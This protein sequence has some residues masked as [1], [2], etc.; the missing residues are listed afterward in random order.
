MIFPGL[1]GTPHPDRPDA[2]PAVEYARMSDLDNDARIPDQFSR[3]EAYGDRTGAYWIA[4]CFWDDGISAWR[5]DAHRPQFEEFLEVLRSEKYRTVV[6]WE[7]SRITRDPVVGAKFGR[8]MQRLRGVL[9]VTDGEKA[10]VYNFARQ[11]DRDS[12]H[13]AVGKSVS[14]SGLKSELVKRKQETK[15]EA[16]EF[17]GSPVGFGW[18]STIV[19]RGRKFHTVWSVDESQ[20]VW[21]REAARRIR[22]G[23]GAL[24]V[25]NDFYD[26][27]LRIPHRRTGPNDTATEG[28][29]TAQTLT[30]TLRNP[31][32]AGL[33]GSGDANTGWTVVGPIVNFPGILSED[34][35]RETVAALGTAPKRRGTS[36]RV[37]HTYAGW[38]VCHKCGRSLIRNSP[39][40]DALWRHRLGKARTHFECDQS[41]HIAAAAAE[42]MMDEL[43]S[44]YLK[45]RAW[46]KPGQIHNADDLRAERT[47]KEADLA[48]LPDAVAD[49][50]VTLEFAGQLERRWKQRLREIDAELNRQA[51]FMI[52]LDGDKALQEWETGTLTQRRRVL[53]TILERIVVIPGKDLPLTE[54]LT[55]QWRSPHATS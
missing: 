28:S 13:N 31:R 23:E 21:L 47:K 44:R 38:F 53:S 19:R 22:E 33:Y 17:P 41:F 39:R 11:R 54:R 20:A 52:V 32:I 36:T 26:R 40:K 35:W 43:V 1:R 29:L 45:S 2:D 34:E 16:R 42:K 14:D 10:T 5:E 30:N 51:R 46:E 6:V 7:E 27:G 15:R 37:Q 49:E 12:W 48:T 50:T 55:V 25:A 4:D 24:K 18:S 3:G 9:Y 8:L